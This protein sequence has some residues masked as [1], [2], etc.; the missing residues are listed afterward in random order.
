VVRN[1]CSY[2]RFVIFIVLMQ[3][4]FHQMTEQELMH[5]FNRY[6]TESSAYRVIMKTIILLGYSLV[7]LMALFQY[8]HNLHTTDEELKSNIAIPALI[9][10]TILVVVT[11]VLAYYVNVH[12]LRLDLRHQQKR[13]D[14]VA[15]I[16]MEYFDANNKYTIYTNH[17]FEKILDASPAEFNQY[18]VGD[19][20]N[21]ECAAHS[22][23]FFSYF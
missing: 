8:Y 17:P 5:I 19:E 18:R 12:P 22:K 6:Q 15:I 10:M 4:T 7:G 3:S 13:S 11:G 23:E 16:S 9:T 21:I 20:I 1:D 14:A 2:K